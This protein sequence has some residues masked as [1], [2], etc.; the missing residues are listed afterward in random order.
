MGKVKTIIMYMTIDRSL[1]AICAWRGDCN[2]K[3]MQGN[4]VYCPDYT[5]DLTIRAKAEEK[6][7]GLNLKAADKKGKKKSR[8]IHFL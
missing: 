8:E 7:E 6:K 2:K 1:C 3:F 4:G 5:K